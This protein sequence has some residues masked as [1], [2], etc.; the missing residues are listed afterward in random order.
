[1]CTPQLFTH[2]FYFPLFIRRT[3]IKF[4]LCTR[5]VVTIL[6]MVFACR[7][8]RSLYNILTARRTNVEEYKCRNQLPCLVLLI[9]L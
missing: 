2:F 3:K 5:N 7:I 8:I 4:P 6:C 9:R 1:M